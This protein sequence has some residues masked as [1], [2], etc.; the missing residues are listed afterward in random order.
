MHTDYQL[1]QID[2]ETLAKFCIKSLTQ[3][4]MSFDIKIAVF[5][6]RKHRVD[7]DQEKL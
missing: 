4:Y 3:Y 1:E 5:C 6:S 2:L 7:T